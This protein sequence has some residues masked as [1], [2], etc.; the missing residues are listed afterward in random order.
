MIPACISLFLVQSICSYGTTLELPL[1]MR[2]ESGRNWGNLRWVLSFLNVTGK[3]GRG[4]LNTSSH[5]YFFIYNYFLYHLYASVVSR[6]V[7]CS[8]YFCT[9]R[10]ESQLIDS[11]ELFVATK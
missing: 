10:I 5:F 6:H 1:K 9:P 8:H 11:Q 4:S 7:C 2:Q 3:S